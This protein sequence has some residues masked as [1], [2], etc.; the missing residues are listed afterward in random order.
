MTFW[1]QNTEW[2][3]SSHWV[4]WK[5][6]D[7]SLSISWHGHTGHV[8]LST[9]DWPAGLSVSK[10]KNITISDMAKKSTI[11]QP[12]LQARILQCVFASLVQKTKT[13]RSFWF[14][15]S[16]K[17]MFFV[18]SSSL[19]PISEFFKWGWHNIESLFWETNRRA[20]YYITSSFE[21]SLCPKLKFFPNRVSRGRL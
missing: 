9:P 12:L 13:Y 6:I 14:T 1:A 10:E 2:K 11:M 16:S 3:Y 21:N 5:L 20:V 18:Q 4:M 15:E 7:S 8:L 19:Q 17:L